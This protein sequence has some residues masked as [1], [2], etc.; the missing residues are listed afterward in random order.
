MPR[1]PSERGGKAIE[2]RILFALHDTRT[3]IHIQRK[4]EKATHMYAYARAQA[5]DCFGE[6]FNEDG[7]CV[8]CD[9]ARFFP[10]GLLS[11]VKQEIVFFRN[12]LL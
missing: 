5:R 7:E 6:N 4:G 2:C 12:R 11:S 10:T 1:P 9:E 8:I 3:C